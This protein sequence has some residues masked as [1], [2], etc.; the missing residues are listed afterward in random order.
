MSAEKTADDASGATD[1]IAKAPHVTDRVEAKD[2]RASLSAMVSAEAEQL[3]A[4]ASAVGVASVEGDA[5]VGTSFVGVVSAKGD[6]TI[7][8]SVAGAVIGGESVSVSQGGSPVLISRAISMNTGAGGA[9]L[10][11]EANVQ[12][13]WIGVLLTPKATISEDSR[14]LIGPAA[15]LILSVAVLGGFGI[16][17]YFA[18]RGAKRML[19]WRPQL[20]ARIMESDA[21][22]KWQQHRG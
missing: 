6:T 22:R 16:A 14:V 15:A 4:T 11:G 8:Q 10:A 13:G 19:A 3:D 12:R 1:A 18:A 17:A 21:L 20:A 7:H 5:D 2:M 9:I